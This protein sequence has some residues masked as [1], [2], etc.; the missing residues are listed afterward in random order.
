MNSELLTKLQVL[1]HFCFENYEL[2]IRKR[3]AAINTA[4]AVITVWDNHNIQTQKLYRVADKIQALFAEYY[5]YRQ[6]RGQNGVRVLQRRAAYLTELTEIFDISKIID[7]LPGPEN[8]ENIPPVLPA[9]NAGPAQELNQ[10]YSQGAESIEVEPVHDF[11][12]I[13]EAGTSAMNVG[14]LL[15]DCWRKTH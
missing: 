13:P 10:R 5:N 1:K 3:D 2:K 7:I 14:G 6:K 15:E 9:Y 11:G 4:K 8:E 12:Q